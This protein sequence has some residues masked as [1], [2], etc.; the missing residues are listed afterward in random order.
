[1]F[2]NKLCNFISL[3]ISPSQSRDE[4]ENYVYNLDLTLEVLTQ[5]NPFLIVIIGDFNARFN[6]WCFTNK[7]TAEEA[8]LDN[9]TSQYGLTQILKKPTH[10]SDN[11]GPVSI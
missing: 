2:S 3:Y 9:L 5:K 10:I 1:M 7:T 11:L 4:F 6:T 8:K